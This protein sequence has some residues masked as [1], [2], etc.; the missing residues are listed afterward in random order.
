MDAKLIGPIITLLVALIG[1]AIAF[2]Q[3]HVKFKTFN[4]FD[5]MFLN[6]S[7]QKQLTDFQFLSEWLL[8]C[9]AMYIMPLVAFT[10]FGELP[11]K[12]AQYVG[13]FGLLIMMISIA[14]C[15]PFYIYATQKNLPKEKYSKARKLVFTNMILSLLGM[16]P[17]S[18]LVASRKDWIAILTM[19]LM[20]LLYSLILT[21][22]TIK[23]RKYPPRTEYLVDILTEEELKKN[24]LIHAYVI[25]DKKSV[26]YHGADLTKN[27]FY[28]CDF[29]SKI[30]LKYTKLHELNLPVDE[31][32]PGNTT[33]NSNGGTNKK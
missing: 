14:F 32:P 31:I 17:I 1:N 25:D 11:K 16:Y 28:V 33:S 3:L 9:F 30:Y 10:Q 12:S 2:Y 4:E 8:L 26:L 19:I 22:V 29:S 13:L 7:E 21:L 23:I 15:V 27:T 5:K 24:P 18:Y 6:K 20:G